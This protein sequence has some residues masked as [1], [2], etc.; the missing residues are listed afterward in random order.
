MRRLV[1]HGPGDVRLEEAPTPAPGPGEVL[2]AL[3][4][5]LTGGTVRKT[6]ARGSHARFG[7]PPLPLGHEGVGRIE[8][9]GAGVRGWSLHERVLPGDS[10]ACGRCR[11]CARGRGVLCGSMRWLTGML[12][13]HV[14]VPAPIVVGNLHRVPAGLASEVAALADN[15]ASVLHGV[16]RTPAAPHDRALVIGS[17]P[18][19][20]LWCWALSGAGAEVTLAGRRAAPLAEAA[21]FGARSTWLLPADGAILPPA[22]PF[23]LVVEAVGQ[24]TTWSLALEAVAP[25]GAVNGFG[26]P[27]DGT[28]LAVDARRLHYEEL[29]LSA[30]FH[31]AP[32]HLARA[33]ALLAGPG[34]FAGLLEQRTLTLEEAAA[35]LG[36]GG[37]GKAVVRPG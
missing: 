22:E 13:D 32:R 24:P 14:L 17:G 28:R 3:E 26:G 29:T 36:R 34:P 7:P 8:A 16:E 23:D 20:L 31:Y 5:A 19:G 35:A 27:P 25:G 6:V 10:A 9:L 4:T 1:L 11:A 15:L 2:L 33:L 12:A 21:A 37:S 30:S 18:L